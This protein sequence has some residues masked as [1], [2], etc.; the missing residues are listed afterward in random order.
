MLPEEQR[1]RLHRAVG[2]VIDRH[3]G[4]VDVVY[5]VQLYLATR[6]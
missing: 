2:E 3:G 4:S 1:V 5:D 6:T